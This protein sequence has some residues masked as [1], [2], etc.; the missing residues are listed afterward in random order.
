MQSVVLSYKL[1][2]YPSANKADTLAL[3]ASLFASCHADCTLEL[4]RGQGRCPSTKGMGEFIGRA[5]RRAFTDYR[6]GAKAAR[7]LRKSHQLGVLHA[8]LIDSADIQTPKH[9]TGFDY[10]ILIKGTKEKGGFYIPAR[11]HRGLQ[12]T[13][14]LPGAVLNTGTKG[15]AFVFRKNG[16]WY[17]QVSVTVPV[18]E[19][20]KPTGF[21]G[22]DVGVRRSVVR[23]DGY[24]GPDLRPVLKK[25]RDRR[26]MQQ[27]HGI[28][29]RSNGTFQKQVLA[30]EAR[31][32]VSVAQRTGQGIALEDPKRLPRWKQWAGRF[33]AERVLLLCQI[34]GVPASVIAPLYTSITCS[35]CGSV[36]RR[37]RHKETFRCWQCGFT[38]NAD[39]NASRNIADRAYRVTAVSHGIL[40]APPGGVGVSG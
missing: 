3:L 29:K 21:L 28:H 8:E 7:A 33:F 14:A 16:K 18:K 31:R 38:H 37:Q 30:R 10:W 13:L 11:S 15:S 2:L 24:R 27:K 40:R 36:E 35:R 34:V 26:A 32:A 22:C 6:R 17:V 4:A 5:Y 23:S 20:A 19:P 39:L 12:R 25:Q 1:K 9:A